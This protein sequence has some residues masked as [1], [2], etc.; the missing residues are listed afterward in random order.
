MNAPS[1]AYLQLSVQVLLVCVF[2]LGGGYRFF[3]PSMALARRMLWVK[4]FKPGIVRFICMIEVVC[5]IGLLLPLIFSDF[6]TSLFFYSRSLLIVTMLGAV[7]THT[8]IGDYKQIFG[9]LCLIG[10]LCY[11]TFP[12]S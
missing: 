2:A 11:I 6:S 7:V 9:N 1:M 12:I 5:G 4:Y 10:M 3:S 8:I